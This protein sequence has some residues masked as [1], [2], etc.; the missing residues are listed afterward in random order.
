MAWVEYSRVDEKR[1]ASGA[2]G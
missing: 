2:E 1:I